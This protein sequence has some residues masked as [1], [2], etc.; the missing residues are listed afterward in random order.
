MTPT[1]RPF[2]V[3]KSCLSPMPGSSTSSTSMPS[4]GDRGSRVLMVGVTQPTETGG[5]LAEAM[6]RDAARVDETGGRLSDA[7]DALRANNVLA[8]LHQGMNVADL[9]QMTANGPAIVAGQGHAIVVDRVADGM[10]YVRDPEPY[11]IGSSY[12]V[13]VDRFTAWWSGRAVV[14][15]G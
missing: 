7:A 5:D 6:W 8:E 12:A 14:V 3:R 4:S 1:R 11:G 10:V 15:T 9:R 2:S 13:P